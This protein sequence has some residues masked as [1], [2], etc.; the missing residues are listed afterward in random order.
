[1][2]IEE[3]TNR[4]FRVWETG[5]YREIPVSEGFRHTSP[6]GTIEGKGTYL[7][8]VE[9]NTD[10]FL[11]NQITIQDAIYSKDRACVRYSI[12][13]KSFSMEVSEWLYSSDGLISEIISYYNIEGEIPEGRKLSDN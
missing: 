12:T 10:K 3:L 9:A 8:L 6:Y 13:N 5:T 11:G 7:A 1:M 4:W 2:Q